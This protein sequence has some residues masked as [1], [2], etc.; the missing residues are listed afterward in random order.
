[1]SDNSLFEALGSRA[2]FHATYGGADFGECWQAAQRVGDGG[3][4]DWYREWTAMAD[5][6]VEEGDVSAARGHRV[7]AREAYLRATT[8][9]RTGYSPLYGAPVD[10]RL[11]AGFDREVDAFATAA[12]LWDV[13]VELVE[14]PFEDG[15]TLPGVFV[16][17]AQPR[18]TI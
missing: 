3:V 4:E 16:G 14:I 12:P 5:R 11:K 8:Y 13:P 17:A 15:A 2:L 7:S 1:M 18:G 10:D 6:L 9:Y